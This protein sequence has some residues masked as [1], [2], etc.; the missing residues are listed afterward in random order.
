[1]APQYR[2]GP[3]PP[4]RPYDSGQETVRPLEGLYHQGD[5]ELRLFDAWAE[6]HVRIGG[7]RIAVY[8]IDPAG[9][10]MSAVHDEVTDRRYRGPFP[11]WGWAEYPEGQPVVT[12]PGV[13]IRWPVKFWVPRA[14]IEKA[15]APAPME[16]DIIRF[17]DKPFFTAN[18]DSDLP[19]E[20]GYFF[21]ITKVNEDGHPYDDP[22]F[23]G[24]SFEGTRDTAFSPERRMDDRV[25]R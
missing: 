22:G 12:D 20:G 23:V 19:T 25:R 18:G 3:V 17:W 6:E 8:S 15:R 16:G 21:L 14:S 24:F 13:T 4:V 11:M 5:Q 10:T 9:S 1:M 2:R 7:T